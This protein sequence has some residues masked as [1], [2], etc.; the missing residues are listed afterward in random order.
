M[1]VR[2]LDPVRLLLR[3]SVLVVVDLGAHALADSAVVPGRA[4]R[5]GV[6]VRSSVFVVIIAAD[7]VLARLDYAGHA[8]PQLNG[9]GGSHGGHGDGRPAADR[10]EPCHEARGALGENA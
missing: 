2:V 1:L 5:A 3:L 9:I 7:L 8:L 10:Q 4:R 6:H